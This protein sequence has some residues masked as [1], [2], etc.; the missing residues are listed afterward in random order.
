MTDYEV[1]WYYK[2]EGRAEERA[3]IVAWLRSGHPDYIMSKA[4]Q[5]ERGAHLQHGKITCERQ[6]IG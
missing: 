4:D 6:S 5:I 1:H 3:A 2:N